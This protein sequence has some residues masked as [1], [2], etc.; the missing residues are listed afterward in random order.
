MLAETPVPQR[1]ALA[2]LQFLPHS[3]TLYQIVLI[4]RHFATPT[5]SLRINT[6]LVSLGQTLYQAVP[7]ESNS[8]TSCC[9]T[10]L[11]NV[12]GN[13]GETQWLEE[14]EQQVE[15]SVDVPYPPLQFPFASFLFISTI[16]L[17]SLSQSSLFSLSTIPSFSSDQLS[18]HCPPKINTSSF[19]TFCF[20]ND[21][22]SVSHHDIFIE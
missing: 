17:C 19:I 2:I 1:E 12:V 3:R 16:S 7:L 10:L 21:M 8:N 15:A 22:H 9:S 13:T 20:T 18:I 11:Q 14:A 5:T 4:I 6:S